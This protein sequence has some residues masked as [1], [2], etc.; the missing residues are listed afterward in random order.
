MVTNEQLHQIAAEIAHWPRYTD[1]DWVTAAEQV[2]R[3]T[4]WLGGEVVLPEEALEQVLLM[5]EHLH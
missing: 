5:A 4:G 1:V 2:N 3:T